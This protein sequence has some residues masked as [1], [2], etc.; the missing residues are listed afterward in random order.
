MYRSFYPGRRERYYRSRRPEMTLALVVEGEHRTARRE[1]GVVVIQVSGGLAVRHTHEACRLGLVLLRELVPEVAD[2]S[3]R[4]LTGVRRQRGAGRRGRNG[5][6]ARVSKGPC[7][8]PPPRC[9]GGGAGH[10]GRS[11]Q[12]VEGGE[13]PLVL[14]SAVLLDERVV[15]RDG[16]TDEVGDH[17]GLF[18]DGRVEPGQ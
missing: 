8:R 10:V 6:R 1:P 15:G 4:G 14:R 9:E 17:V 7:G 12:H 2:V 5:S 13:A 11:W 3:R 16:L 18:V